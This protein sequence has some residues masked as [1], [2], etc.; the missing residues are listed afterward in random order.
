MKFSIPVMV[1]ISMHKVKGFS[2]S[3]ANYANISIYANY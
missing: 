3:Y 2:S 1:I